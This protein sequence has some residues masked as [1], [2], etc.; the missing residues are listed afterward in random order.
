[1][2]KK[3]DGGAFPWKVHPAL[4]WTISTFLLLVFI[5]PGI[6][7][8][9]EAFHCYSAWL[10]GISEH[11]TITLT[12]PTTWGGLHLAYADPYLPTDHYWSVPLTMLLVIGLWI[13]WADTVGD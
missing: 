9:H 11:C 8:A 12:H 10:A 3:E 5:G 2:I 4:K 13:M 6:L 1:M 7:M